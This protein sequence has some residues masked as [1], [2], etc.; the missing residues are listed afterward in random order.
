MIQDLNLHCKRCGNCCQGL[1]WMKRF[2]FTEAFNLTRGSKTK[3]KIE[4]SVVA[5]YRK[6]LQ[7]NGVP[8]KKL[9]D[10]LWDKNTKIIT[11]QME[12][13][14]CKFLRFAKDNKAICTIYTKRPDECK[15]YLCRKVRNKIH[16]L[17]KRK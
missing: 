15:T 8:V 10:L 9:H 14:R 4:K 3:S 16:F 13:G 11:V 1:V 6:Y 17:K 12:T 7:K 5:N 2:G